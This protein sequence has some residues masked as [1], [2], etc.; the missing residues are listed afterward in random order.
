M[1]RVKALTPEQRAKDGVYNFIKAQNA[2]R[3][4]KQLDI[5]R[6][7]NVSQPDVSY[8]LKNRTLTVCGCREIVMNVYGMYLHEAFTQ[9]EKF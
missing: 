7:L 6:A 5:A 8:K 4:V 1:P 2:I 3:N 9:I